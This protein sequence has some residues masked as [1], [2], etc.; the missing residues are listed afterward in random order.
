[1]GLGAEDREMNNTGS[2][3]EE[4]W[5]QGEKRGGGPTGSEKRLGFPVRKDEYRVSQP[6]GTDAEG[7]C[8]EVQKPEED[9]GK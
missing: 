4:L 9:S 6:K 2:F 5:F 3:L 1:M 8:A 7:L